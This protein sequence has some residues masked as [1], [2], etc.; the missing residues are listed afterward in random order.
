MDRFLR[1][2]WGIVLAL[3]VIAAIFFTFWIVLVVLLAGAILGGLYYVY[4]RFLRKKPP[5]PI[6]RRMIYDVYEEG[7]KENEDKKAE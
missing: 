1:I 2:L 3:M 7:R 5:A 6:D 4:N